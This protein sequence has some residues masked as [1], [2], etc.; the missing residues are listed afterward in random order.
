MA[1]SG[2]FKKRAL[3]RCVTQKYVKI[4]PFSEKRALFCQILQRA[5]SDYQT[6]ISS[7]LFPV[8]SF[9][10]GLNKLLHFLHF[11]LITLLVKCVITNPFLKL[12][13]WHFLKFQIVFIITGFSNKEV[14]QMVLI[15]HS[16][17]SPTLSLLLIFV[18]V[19]PRNITI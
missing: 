12:S 15:N 19:H 14:K 4:T 10:N 5:A 8:F 18:F 16:W 7:G 11:K 3:W 1:A 2:I 9:I 6:L 13:K 17:I